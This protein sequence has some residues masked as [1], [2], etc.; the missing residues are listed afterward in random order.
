MM[1]DFDT[2]KT[3]LNDIKGENFRKILFDLPPFG[4][5]GVLYMTYVM[6]DDSLGTVN[7]ITSD[8]GGSS[9]VKISRQC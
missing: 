9:D 8:K 1:Y 3:S 6:A 2:H 5:T 7:F 4:Y